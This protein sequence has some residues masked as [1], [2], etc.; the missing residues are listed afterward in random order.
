MN[1]AD[2]V[3]CSTMWKKASLNV[4]YSAIATGSS[5]ITIK[6]FFVTFRVFAK[7]VMRRSERT[8]STIFYVAL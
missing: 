2:C 1:K 3:Q 4:S 8:N 5:D 6:P 7:P